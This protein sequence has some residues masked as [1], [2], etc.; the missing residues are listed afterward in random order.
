MIMMN[1]KE[2]EDFQKP[3]RK[4]PGSKKKQFKERGERIVPEDRIYK[5]SKI[6]PKDVDR[7]LDEDDLMD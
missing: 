6:T 2:D 1:R 3:S 7:Y 4:V 5:R